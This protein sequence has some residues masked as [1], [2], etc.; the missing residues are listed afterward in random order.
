[1][2]FQHKPS[3]GVLLPLN[4]MIVDIHQNP[5]IFSMCS[6]EFLHFLLCFLDSIS[7]LLFIINN[8]HAYK[9]STSCIYFIFTCMLAPHI[10]FSLDIIAYIH[11][12]LYST[13]PLICCAGT[14]PIVEGTLGS[15]I[16]WGALWG[17]DVTWSYVILII[18]NDNN[19]K[20]SFSSSYWLSSRIVEHMAF[21]FATSKTLDVILI[22]W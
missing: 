3:P 16:H 9:P 4:E 8:L 13:R 6:R 21:K 2:T 1:M 10:L 5:T 7:F 18:S 19:K 17:I 20:K 14:F 22:L 11:D 15:H 12:N